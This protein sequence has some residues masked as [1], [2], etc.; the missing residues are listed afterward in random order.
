MVELVEDAGFAQGGV[1]GLRGGVQAAVA[2]RL[3]A[4][5]PG[6]FGL[7]NEVVHA[8]R[9]ARRALH[10]GKT[11]QP[12]V[13]LMAQRRRLVEQGV[14]CLKRELAQQ[15]GGAQASGQFGRQTLEQA[16][17]EPLRRGGLLN[18]AAQIASA[19]RLAG[20]L[21]GLP[22]LARQVGQQRVAGAVAIDGDGQA[23]VVQA[24]GGEKVLAFCWR[25]QGVIGGILQTN[26]RKTAHMSSRH[27]SCRFRS[28]E[29]C[30]H[31]NC[32]QFIS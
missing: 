23:G 21:P 24:V 26:Q 31:L 28:H 3:V 27:T 6:L 8:R 19:Q 25:P 20:L 14:G 5:V 13:V 29:V 17:K 1:V 7:A 9:L 16:A 10:K 18:A 30:S 2:R 15:G 12:L 4:L 22:Q 32:A 11:Q